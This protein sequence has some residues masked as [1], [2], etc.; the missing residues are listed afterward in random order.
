V[1][2]DVSVPPNPNWH[3]CYLHFGIVGDFDL[4][5]FFSALLL[6]FVSSVVLL[7]CFDRIG[8]W[9]WKWKKR[10]FVCLFGQK[11]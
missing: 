8:M 3:H 11:K 4:K 1:T 9:I 10:F 6:F 2:Q 5:T 7:F